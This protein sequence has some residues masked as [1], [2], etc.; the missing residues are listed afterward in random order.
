[1]PTLKQL[2]NKQFHQ[3][4]V[5]EG[6]AFLQSNR[7]VFPANLG[8]SKYKKDRFRDRYAHF[9][10]GEDSEEEARRRRRTQT[11]CSHSSK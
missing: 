2:N 9:I 11:L 10:L 4:F 5:T 7:R 6:I 1:M 3:K 8:A